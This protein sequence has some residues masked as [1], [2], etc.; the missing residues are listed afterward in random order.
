MFA[1]VFSCATIS[2]LAGKNSLLPT[3]SPWVCVLMMWVTGLSVTDFTLSRIGLAPV[4]EL[5]VHEHHAVGRDECRGVAAAA[6]DHEEVVLHLLDLGDVWSGRRLLLGREWRGRNGEC[7][8]HGDD[9]Q[10]PCACHAPPPV[11][12]SPVH[13]PVLPARITTNRA[14]PR[15]SAGERRPGAGDHRQR[16]SPRADD[17]RA[18]RFRRRR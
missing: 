1:A 8:R 6:G 16:S 10:C 14:P 13:E 5:G 7:A 12:N 18:G 3:W 11:P 4:G 15:Q 17:A 9:T 2:T